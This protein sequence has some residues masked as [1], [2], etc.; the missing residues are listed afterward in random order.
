MGRTECTILGVV[1][2]PASWCEF[3]QS[4]DCGDNLSRDPRGKV[5]YLVSKLCC[6]ITQDT[7]AACPRNIPV[8]MQKK[9][10]PE[11]VVAE[12]CVLVEDD[13]WAPC[14]VVRLRIADPLRIKCWPTDRPTGVAT[15]SF[16]SR[17]FVCGCQRG[18]ERRERERERER[19]SLNPRS[20]RRLPESSRPEH[21]RRRV[22]ERGQLTL[23]TYMLLFVMRA[24]TKSFSEQ[25]D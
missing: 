14:A 21:G 23:L 20:R 17:W 24:M 15:A 1:A 12:D 10:L 9:L 11:T 13:D 7:N 8:F 5:A 19:A 18:N 3:P 2:F 16:S 4:T 22:G 6:S 25:L